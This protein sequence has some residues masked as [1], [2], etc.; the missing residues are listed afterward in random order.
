METTGH[1]SSPGLSYTESSAGTGGSSEEGEGSNQS[2]I[3][4]MNLLSSTVRGPIPRAGTTETCQSQDLI[5]SF[6]SWL[7]LLFLTLVLFIHSTKCTESLLNVMHYSGSWKVVMG[8]MG[9][10]VGK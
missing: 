7:S 5:S 9:G 10:W 6:F 4:G 1:S 2:S 8:Q 3:S